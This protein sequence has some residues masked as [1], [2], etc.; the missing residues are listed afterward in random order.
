MDTLFN[1]KNG[2]REKVSWFAHLRCLLFF[3]HESENRKIHTFLFRFFS[4]WMPLVFEGQY[5]RGDMGDNGPFALARPNPLKTTINELTTRSSQSSYYAFFDFCILKSI[6][7]CSLW[8]H[9]K[10]CPFSGW[11]A[12]KPNEQAYRNLI[13]SLALSPLYIIRQLIT[14]ICLLFPFSFAAART[15]FIIKTKRKNGN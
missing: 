8:L 9:I 14:F 11:S 7:V 4:R 12:K 6:M 10:M 2:G 1:Q 15:F 3:K 13:D 5:P